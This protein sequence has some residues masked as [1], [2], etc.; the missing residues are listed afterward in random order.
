MF[1]ALAVPVLDTTIACGPLVCPTV[2]FPKARESVDAEILGAAGATP[3]PLMA[4]WR[5]EPP[6]KANVRFAVSAPVPP[7]LYVTLSVHAA[8]AGSDV[9]QVLPPVTN[10]AG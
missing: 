6:E 1:V 2:T 9:P 4:T 3:V 7:G 10:F 5:E 8:P